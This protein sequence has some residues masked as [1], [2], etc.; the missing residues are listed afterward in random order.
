MFPYQFIHLDE[1]SQTFS[2]GDS[3]LESPVDQWETVNQDPKESFVER[4]LN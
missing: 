1:V 3:N 4:K 2:N